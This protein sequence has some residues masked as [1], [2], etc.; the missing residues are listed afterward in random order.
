MPAAH[1]VQVLAVPPAENVPAGQAWQIFP[2]RNRPAAQLVTA[3]EQLFDPGSEV[4]PSA[5]GVQVVLPGVE[6]V[7]VG[8]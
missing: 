7:F 3:A 5:H 6:K 1:S 4:I 2:E 8:H